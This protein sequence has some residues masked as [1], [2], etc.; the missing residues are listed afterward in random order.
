MIKSTDYLEVLER[1]KVPEGKNAKR[2]PYYRC[3][4]LRCGNAQYIAT[5]GDINSGRMKSCG[6]FRNSQEFAD[7][8]VVHGQRRQNKGITTGTY[9]S[10]LNL[11]ARCDNPNRWNHQYYG[12]KGI[13]YQADWRHFEAFL[14]DMGERPEGLEL[15]RID[16]TLGYSKENCRWVTHKENCNNR[17][18]DGT[19]AQ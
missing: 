7:T 8:K 5:S 1:V 6:C 15:D 19:Q 4:C 16:N 18:Y 2:G 11:K 12:E 10:W 17:G 13:G 3:R 9:N 14:R